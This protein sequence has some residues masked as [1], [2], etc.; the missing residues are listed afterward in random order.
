[1][2][3]EERPGVNGDQ[4]PYLH[5][6]DVLRGEIHDGVFRVGE[7]LPSQAQLEKRFNVSRPTVQRALTELRRDGYLDN[8]RGRSAEVLDWRGS[9]PASRATHD[10]P[11]PTLS[12][13]EAEVAEAFEARHITIDA[14]SLSSETLTSALSQP[15]NRVLRGEL[16]PASI[17]VRVLLPAL[18]AEL[19]IPRLVEGDERWP[20]ARLR[21]LVGAQAVTL[22]SSF[23]QVRDLL[24]DI[25]LSVETQA[26]PVTPLHKLY[27]LNGKT[28]LTGYY[29]VIERD[30]RYRKLSGT[31]YDVLGL[32]AV[33]FPFRADPADPESLVSRFFAESQGW[34][35]SLWSTISRPLFG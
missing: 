12:V 10:I 13:L 24:P 17:R 8:Q 18:D 28:A 23:N 26:L 22:E 34:F 3:Q 7:R 11:G 35:D 5:I 9:V 1:M 20:L 33:L 4:P 25:D 2:N 21:E 32:D 27:I 15:L 31:I 16:S 6:A 14:Y 29:Q 30:V 19:A